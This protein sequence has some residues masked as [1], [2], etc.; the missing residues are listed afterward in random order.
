MPRVLSAM[1]VRRA[2]DNMIKP[3]RNVMTQLTRRHLFATVAAAGAASAFSSLPAAAQVPK[4]GTSGVFRYSLG[5]AEVIQLLDGIRA[6]K[7]PDTFIVNL[8]KDQMVKAFADA[9]MPG[10]IFRNPYCPSVVKSGGKTIVID[11]GNGIGALAATK[12]EVG[13]HRANLAAA[14]IDT[15]DV[16]I[17]LISHFHGD[18]IGGLKNP[19]GSL[20]YP[21]AEI[22]VPAVEWNYWT[23]DANLAKTPKSNQG[24][25]ANV[26]KVFA[27]LKPTQY[28]AGKEVAPGITAIATPGHTPGH[29]SFVV[30]SGSKRVLIQGDVAFAPAVF[31]KHPDYQLMFDVNG[32]LAVTTRKKFFDMA[33]A[34]KLPII[35]YHFPFGTVSYIEKTGSG[36]NVIPANGGLG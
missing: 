1:V 4:S 25:F 3:G 7:V 15:K 2:I 32:D 9:Y 26:K 33:I 17:V 27:G 8:S 5:D 20:A 23:N 11:T 24:N 14:G 35:A 28:E 22:K 10:G 18:H 21:K 6:I 12:G 34:E 31:V 30:A 13:H 19:D 29:S 36:Y 16:D